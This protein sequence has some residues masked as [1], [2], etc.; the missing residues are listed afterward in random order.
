MKTAVRY[1]LGVVLG[2]VVLLLLVGKRGDLLA[3]WRQLRDANLGWVL[4]A[5]LAEAMSLLTFA[6]LQ[7]RV[8]RLSGARISMPAL[9]LLTMANDAIANTVPGE[10]AVSSAYRYRYYRRRGATGAGA[11]WTIFTILVAQAIGMSLLLLVGVLVALASSTTK[12]GAGTA[13]VGLVIVAGGGAVL[14]RRDLVIGLAGKAVRGV[15]RV[16]G[17]PRGDLGAR[18]ESTLARMREIPM[19]R[20]STVGVV[21]LATSV[22]CCDCL[23]LV[24][25]FGAV[26]V[27]VPWN[28]VLLAY[29]VAQVVASFP[30]VPGG[31]GIVEGSLAVILA[32]YGTGRVP[33]VS[34]A[35]GFRIVN[36]WLAITVGWVSVAVIAW[37]GRRRADAGIALTPGGDLEAIAAVP[38]E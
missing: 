3:S 12:G 14:V 10:P 13:L 36:F 7:H 2:V 28:G 29:G 35:V 8:L 4:L 18:I 34:A 5:V 37:L 11:G 23:C 20:P 30:V 16:T 33:A 22:W 9:F 21:A 17:H 31:I 19:S 38:P 15:R 6:W 25:A 32:A 24:C 27:A 26:R 1:V